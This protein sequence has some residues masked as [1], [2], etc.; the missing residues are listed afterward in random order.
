MEGE[1]VLQELKGGSGGSGFRLQVLDP[2]HHQYES[3]R[4]QFTDKWL[5]NP[6]APRVENIFKI[7]VSL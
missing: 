7:L 4:K 1:R 2:S 6:T 3:V 5:K